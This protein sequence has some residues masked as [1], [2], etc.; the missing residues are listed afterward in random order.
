MSYRIRYGTP[1][2]RAAGWP[3]MSCLFLLL[4][5]GFTLAHWPEGRV[6]LL[7]WLIPGL[8]VTGPAAEAFL[9][10][11]EQGG[12]LGEGLLGLLRELL[13]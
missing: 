13:G 2:P 8:E 3:W 1:A 5:L 7:R 10:V 6:V 12:S 4:F 9:Q 11:S